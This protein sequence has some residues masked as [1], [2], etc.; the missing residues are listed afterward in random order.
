MEANSPYELQHSATQALEEAKQLVEEVKKV[1][2]TIISIFHYHFLG[3]DKMFHGW[4]EVYE[5]LV[6]GEINFAKVQDD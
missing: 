4:R 6:A 5:E 1:N 2:G 3:N